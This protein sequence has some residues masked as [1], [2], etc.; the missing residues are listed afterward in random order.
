[1]RCLQSSQGEDVG[2]IL[3]AG[4]DR[5]LNGRGQILGQGHGK[6]NLD[7]ERPGKNASHLAPN[8]FSKRSQCRSCEIGKKIGPG[9]GRAENQAARQRRPYRVNPRRMVDLGEL[10]RPRETQGQQE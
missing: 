8:D 1:V 4:E 7:A 9:K 5:F 6:D 10:H 3:P 2:A